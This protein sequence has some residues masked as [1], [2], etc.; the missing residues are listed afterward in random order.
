MDMRFS[1]I[2]RRCFPIR[3]V[4]VSSW[5]FFLPANT[6]AESKTAGVFY[7]EKTRANAIANAARHEWAR[8]QREQAVAAAKPWIEKSDDE[9]WSMI[10]S[11]KLKRAIMVNVNK[12]C[13]NCGDKIYGER[14]PHPYPFQGWV[15]GHPW[16]VQCPNCKELFPKND[17]GA[18]YRSGLDPKTHLFDP[19]LADRKLLFNTEHPDPNDPKHGYAVDDGN[20]WQRF[21][22]GLS[23]RDWYVAYHTYFG[24]NGQITSAVRN[25]ATAYSLTGESV[26]AHKATVLLD[27]L[28]DVFPDYDG[29]NQQFFNNVWGEYSSGI[30]GPNYWDG[31]MW[32]Q[33]AIDYDMIFD[34]MDDRPE[35]LAFLREKSHKYKVPLPK[36]SVSDLRRNIEQRI[37]IE[38]GNH[39]DRIDMNG[40]ITDMCR[41]TVDLV[42][43]GSAGFEDFLQRAL[44]VIVPPE[45]LNNDGSGNERSIGYD[46]GAF[47]QYCQLIEQ[48][49]RL[50]RKLVGQAL[51]RFPKLRAAF[52]FWPDIWCVEQYMPLIGDT[53]SPGDTGSL[54]GTPGAYLVLFDITGAARYAQVAVRMVGGD[55]D[56][57]PRDIY[58]A[59][60][61]GLIDRAVEADRKAGPWRTKSLFKPDYRLAILRGGAEATPYAL[62]LF[63][64]P[65]PGTSSHS[66]FDALNFGLFAFGLPLVCEQGYPLYTGA[67]P[68]RWDWT[69][70]TRSHA[71]VTVEEK[72]Q[73]HC[74]E[75]K[76]LAFAEQDG[77]RLVAAETPCVYDMVPRYRRTLITVDVAEGQTFVLDV[78][79]V[80]GGRM[81]TYAVPMF[82]GGFGESAGLELA[83]HED[84]Y[85]GYV[86]RV[87]AAR[88]AFNWWVDT[89]I[90]ENWQGAAAAHLRIHGP[91]FDGEIL[92]GE[93]QSRWGGQ[94]PRWLPYLFQRRH[95]PGADLDSTFVTMFEPY[96]G[97]PFLVGESLEAVIQPEGVEVRVRTN[98]PGGDYRL[99]VR[100]GKADLVSAEI[101]CSSRPNQAPIRLAGVERSENH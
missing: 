97:R 87:Q 6:S 43:R 48:L 86:K 40:S 79:R 56:K 29:R 17:F 36:E 58:A 63:Y 37:L 78:F 13:P 101:R 71:T 60:P 24:L 51:A 30:L 34:G 47:G 11:P 81:H 10:V 66:H 2:N 14:G 35:T 89:A 50:D 94:D 67:W 92:L 8:K 25:L 19:A 64:S 93:G 55:R 96:R 5:I 52:D 15:P 46:S 42:L 53:G 100:D 1:R 70:N 12:G 74:S 77:V 76:L 31:G 33:R 65:D 59:D 18:Y 4:V 69:S 75:A 7:N 38:T 9:L 22:G 28:A 88:A 84:I 23:E 99:E 90:H 16:K 39:P 98:A 85:W 26:Y 20:G 80:K 45:H 91:A 61:E 49:A 95:N 54:A 72:C 44:P 82:F 21:P 68:A 57:L 83:P 27:R 73:K 41:A 62:W 32:S 3:Y